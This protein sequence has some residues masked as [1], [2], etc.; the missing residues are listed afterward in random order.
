MHEIAELARALGPSGAAVVVVV[1]F[2]CHMRE[3]SRRHDMMIGNHLTHTRKE[4]E[5]MANQHITM[6]AVLRE[7]NLALHELVARLSGRE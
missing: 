4:H 7:V 5:D 1:L 3:Q 6:T 2:L